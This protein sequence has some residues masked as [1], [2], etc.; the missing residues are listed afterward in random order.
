MTKKRISSAGTDHRRLLPA[1]DGHRRRR[2]FSI[3]S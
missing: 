2:S 3:C 1:A